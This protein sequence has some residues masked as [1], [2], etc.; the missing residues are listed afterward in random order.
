VV[1]GQQRA[2]RGERVGAGAQRRRDDDAVAR[3]ARVRRAVHVD[4]EH[5]LTR[6]AA[7]DDDVV[8][9]RLHLLAVPGDGETGELPAAPVAAGEAVERVV[10]LRR[11]RGREDPEA[12]AGDA[13]DGPAAGPVERR[14][15]RPVT[16]D[17]EQEVARP[18]LD[19]LGDPPVLSGHEDLADDGA[20][21]AGPGADVLERRVEIARRVDDEAEGADGHRQ[22]G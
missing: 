3:G 2:A 9:R 20:V 13:E 14:Q 10:D 18:G 21:L 8:D 22:P 11:R 1:G 19:R 15:D 5:D 12:P 16:A 17:G 4:V 7:D 6:P